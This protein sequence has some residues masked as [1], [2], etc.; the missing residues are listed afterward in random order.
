MPT[1]TRTIVVEDF[2]AWQR[3]AAT[4]GVVAQGQ[5]FWHEESGTL[6]IS[7]ARAWQFD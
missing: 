6:F 1:P 2:N 5:D 3:L 7:P 4:P